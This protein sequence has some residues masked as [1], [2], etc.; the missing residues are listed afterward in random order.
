[1][2]HQKSTAPAA[3]TGVALVV[4]PCRVL[5]APSGSAPAQRLEAARLLARLLLPTGSPRREVCGRE[6]RH[7]EQG[8]AQQR[9]SIRRAQRLLC[10]SERLPDVGRGEERHADDAHASERDLH[11]R[12]RPEREERVPHAQQRRVRQHRHPQAEEPARGEQRDRH[13][14]R[15]EPL[16]QVRAVGPREGA[17]DVAVD[18]VAAHRGREVAYAPPP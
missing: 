4:L 14:E 18:G 5:A 2:T 9:A 15:L 7:V 10:A 16:G 17:E 8:G 6:A 1:M 12:A 13:V 3:S 11:G